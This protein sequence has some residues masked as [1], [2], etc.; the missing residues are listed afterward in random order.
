MSQKY[1][2]ASPEW[3]R[4]FHRI[5]SDLPRGTLTGIDYSHWEE[6]TSAPSDLSEPGSSSVSFHYQIDDG[7]VEAGPG[8]LETWDVKITIDY[9]TALVLTHT[10]THDPDS[11]ARANDEMTSAFTDGRLQIEGD[12]SKRPAFLSDLHD[13]IASITR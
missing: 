11:A 10:S 13:S 6:L 1:D 12:L 9:Q 4:E 5:L 2:L 8:L 7:I 3:V